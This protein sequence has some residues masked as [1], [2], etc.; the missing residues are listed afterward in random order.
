M[1]NILKI[2]K[3]PSFTYLEI[4]KKVVNNKFT[5]SAASYFPSIDNQ[6]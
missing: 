4:Q 3:L 1:A 6:A 5:L 2:Q